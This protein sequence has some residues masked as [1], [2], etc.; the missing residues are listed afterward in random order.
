MEAT[1]LIVNFGCNHRSPALP[2]HDSEK[3]WQKLRE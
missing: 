1:S 2:Q 3:E